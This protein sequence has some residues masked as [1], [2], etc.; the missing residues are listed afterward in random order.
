MALRFVI[1]VVIEERCKR[2]WAIED[3]VIEDWS[4]EKQA[5]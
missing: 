3:C 1:L 5:R 2:D 4:I